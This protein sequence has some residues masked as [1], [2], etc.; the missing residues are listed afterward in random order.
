[1]HGKIFLPVAELS[2]CVCHV[3]Y[4]LEYFA[5]LQIAVGRWITVQ[6]PLEGIGYLSS[7]KKNGSKE[8]FF[9]SEKDLEAKHIFSQF[10]R[11]FLI[12]LDFIKFQENFELLLG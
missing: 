6:S 12:Y 10:S 3:K 9:F 11:H 7:L 4:T 8:A 5:V 1:M 2:I